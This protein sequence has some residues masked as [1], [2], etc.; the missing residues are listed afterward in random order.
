MRLVN[1]DNGLSVQTLR[2]G[3][4]EQLSER[5]WLI[6]RKNFIQSL[7]E[8]GIDPAGRLKEL[9][10]HDWARGS[11]APVSIMLLS[12]RG[13]L[14]IIEAACTKYGVDFPKFVG[15]LSIPALSRIAREIVWMIRDEEE[16][17]AEGE[18]GAEPNGQ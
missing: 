13:C 8:S 9:R 17:K 6:Q 18:P 15:E 1:G 11:T 3:D 10:E 16:T 2:R 7:D 5:A 14:D 4:I 12:I